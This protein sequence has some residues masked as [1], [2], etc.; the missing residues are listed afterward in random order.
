MREECASEWHG[1]G[2]VSKIVIAMRA[3]PAGSVV[4]L[5]GGVKNLSLEVLFALAYA[6]AMTKTSCAATSST[7]LT[8]RTPSSC[9]KVPSF[10]TF[11]SCMEPAG[12]GTSVGTPSHS[13]PFSSSISSRPPPSDVG[14]T[15]TGGG[16]S[17]RNSTSRGD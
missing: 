3:Y 10:E 6:K 4:P 5:R 13:S 15:S 11:T 12:S 7:G 1:G 2:H 8:H 16:S 17:P 14:G 9:P